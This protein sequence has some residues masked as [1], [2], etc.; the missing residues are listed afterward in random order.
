MADVSDATDRHETD[1]DYGKPAEALDNDALM[2]RFK[3]WWRQDIPRAKKWHHEAVEDFKFRAGDQWKE[4]D[5]Q[6]MED[7][8]RRACLIFNQVDPVIDAVAGSEVT[9][10]QEVRYI[11]RQIGAA[12]VNEVLTEAARWFRDECDAEDEESSAF[13]DAITTGMGWVETRLD[14]EM[15]PDGDPKIERVDPIEMVWDGAAKQANVLDAR[16]VWRVR[17]EVPLYE[18]REKWPKDAEG[19]VIVDDAD[20][21][22]T[23]A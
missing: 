6:V 10:R 13:A 8:Q 17:R 23:W 19:N 14:Y 11:P 16:R 20:Y 2:V 1:D 3:D 9:N 7:I 21:D 15:N 12:P 4:E 22:A 5:Q 18:A